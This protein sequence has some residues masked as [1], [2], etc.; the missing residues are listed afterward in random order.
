MQR[1]D[2]RSAAR[3]PAADLHETAGVARDHGVD[4]RRLDRLDLLVEHRYRDLRV[5]HRERSSEAATRFGIR[6]LDQLGPAHV[7]QQ[8]PWLALQPEVAQAVTGVV[9]RD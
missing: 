7:A 2:R 4:S 9:P 8:A 6:Q 5:L 3:Q 1:A